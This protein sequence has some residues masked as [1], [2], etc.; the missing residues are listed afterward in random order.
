M[1]RQDLFRPKQSD[2]DLATVSLLL[3]HMQNGEG[4]SIVQQ[5]YHN[6]VAWGSKL[7]FKLHGHTSHACTTACYKGL[8]TETDGSC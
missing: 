8:L 2:S 3:H 7:G 6:I 5:S 4:H 1:G